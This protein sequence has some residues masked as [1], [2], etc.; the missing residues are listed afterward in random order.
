MIL[1]APISLHSYDLA[2]K[3]PLNKVL[4]IMEALKNITFVVKQ[5]YPRELTKIINEANIK[6]I[7]AN[8]PRGR[9]P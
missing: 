7:L 8:R 3:Q 4:E 9:T 2:I 6:S 5:I 1:T